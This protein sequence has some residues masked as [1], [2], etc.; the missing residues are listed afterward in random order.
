MPKRIDDNYATKGEVKYLN[1]LMTLMVIVLF[2]GFGGMFVATGA[3]MIEALQNKSASYNEMTVKILE[4]NNKIDQ[5]S[6][7]LK[8]S[9]ESSLST[10]SASGH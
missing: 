4:Q 7:D 6:S 8:E 10:K 3:M 9:K 5:L 1:N 2:I